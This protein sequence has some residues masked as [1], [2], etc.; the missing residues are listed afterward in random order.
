M[1]TEAAAPPADGPPA[2]PHG[3]DERACASGAGLPSG[4][5]PQR[6]RSPPY[7]LHVKLTLASSP[8]LAKATKSPSPMVTVRRC[9]D[10]MIVGGE[11][12]LMAVPAQQDQPK[13]ERR[14]AQRA[15]S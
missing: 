2:A 8:S 5:A 11:R 3:N 1:E 9:V 13:K 10:M 6:P 14:L 4:R 12:L 15:Q 7:P